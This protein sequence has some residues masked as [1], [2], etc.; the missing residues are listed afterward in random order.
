LQSDPR[1]NTALL[2]ASLPA[3]KKVAPIVCASAEA[4]AVGETVLALGN[5]EGHTLTVRQGVVSAKRE[6]ALQTDAG[7]GNHNA[8]GALISLQGEL[9]AIIDGGARDKVEVAFAQRGEQ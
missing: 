9:V 8:G 2:A 5:P 4:L 6:G 3:G 7:L 1:T